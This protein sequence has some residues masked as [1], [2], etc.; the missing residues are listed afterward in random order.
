MWDTL[1]VRPDTSAFTIPKKTKTT[2][3]SERSSHSAP[4]VEIEE[5]GADWV[6]ESAF[7]SCVTQIPCNLLYLM[8]FELADVA[9]IFMTVLIHPAIIAAGLRYPPVELS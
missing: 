7:P 2:R 8:F 9:M 5:D 4:K 1:T 6:E 3:S